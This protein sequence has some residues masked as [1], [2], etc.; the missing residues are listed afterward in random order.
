MDPYVVLPDRSQYVDQQTL[1][2]QERPEVGG[3]GTF[4]RFSDWADTVLYC[5]V[6]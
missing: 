6:Q 5:A 1:K 3:M 4:S 2:L